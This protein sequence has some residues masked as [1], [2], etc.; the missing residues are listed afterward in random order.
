[1]KVARLDDEKTIADSS[2]GKNAGYT[3]NKSEKG[4]WSNFVIKLA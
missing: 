3:R 2:K 4:C 1:M